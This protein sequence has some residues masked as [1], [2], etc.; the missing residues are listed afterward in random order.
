M[1][2]P[3]NVVEAAT[4]RDQASK[5]NTHGATTCSNWVDM[6]T[7]SR[8]HHATTA[9]RA[10]SVQFLCTAQA[11]LHRFDWPTSVLHKIFA[12]RSTIAWQ[13]LGSGPNAERTRKRLHRQSYEAQDIDF[14]D[15]MDPAN[16]RTLRADP[17]KKKALKSWTKKRLDELVARKHLLQAFQ[18][19]RTL[20]DTVTI[21][22]AAQLGFMVILDPCWSVAAFANRHTKL[23]P[24]VKLFVAGLEKRNDKGR[25]PHALVQDSTVE[26][27]LAIAQVLGGP[28]LAAIIDEFVLDT[29]PTLSFDPVWSE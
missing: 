12:I 6:E 10:H 22:D 21:A 29:T 3:F 28:E 15:G 13:G 16:K 24:A 1:L 2:K 18:S 8:C 26:S 11:Q 9:E 23:A 20:R 27:M 4:I 14:K 7:V 5:L 19:V 17:E 25:S